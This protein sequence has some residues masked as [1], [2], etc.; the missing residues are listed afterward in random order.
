MAIIMKATIGM[1]TL[2]SKKQ[3]GLR[4]YSIIV[5]QSTTIGKSI[6]VDKTA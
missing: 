2:I 1:G 4:I 3:M 5:T 6:T